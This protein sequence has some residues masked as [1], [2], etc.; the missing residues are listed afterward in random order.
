MAGASR[1]IALDIGNSTVKLAQFSVQNGAL[2]LLAYGSRELGLDPNNQDARFPVVAGVLQELVKEFRLKGKPVNISVAGHSVF[3]RFVKLPKVDANQLHQMIGFEA[4]QNVPFPISE[5][6]WDYQLLRGPTPDQNEAIIVAIKSDALEE[7]YRIA[8]L[9]GFRPARVDISTLALYNAYR[10]N[11]ETTDDCTLLIDIGAKS[12]NFFFIEKDRVYIRSGVPLAGNLL[13][14]SIAADLNEPF[15]S[16]ETLKKGKGFVSLGGAYADPDDPEAARI[17][18]VIRNTMTKLH[19]DINRTTI[20]YRT[21][22]G[23]TN[24]RR[25]LLAGGSSRIPY[26]DVFL[27]EKLGLTV[28]F[29]NPLRNVNIGPNLDQRNLTNDMSSM[30][31]LVGLALRETGEC[32]VEVT[33][34]PPS[35]KAARTKANKQPFLLFAAVAFA[36]A[37][38][39]PTLWNIRQTNEQ[40]LLADNLEQE[41]S[42]LDSVK[43]DIQKNAP[44]VKALQDGQNAVDRLHQQ[45]VAWP[46]I[47]GALHSKIPAG[48]WI[49]SLEPVYMSGGKPFAMEAEAVPIDVPPAPPATNAPGKPPGPKPPASTAPKTFA[50]SPPISQINITGLFHSDQQT[51]NVTSQTM[52]GFGIALAELGLFDIDTR[53]INTTIRPGTSAANTELALKFDMELKLKQ[54]LPTTP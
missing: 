51:T 50:G 35:V 32:P 34:E 13:T 30:G 40:N 17:S 44:E 39:L 49:T 46:R 11:Y 53:N 14:Q 47:L 24:P 42:R 48:S 9:G 54:P 8:S 20:L 15:A 31:E 45:I 36:V 25:V 3:T 33:L 29:F 19:N 38:A 6:T 43:K 26:L 37:M 16:A 52:L 10:Y 18:K 4:Q 22:Q 21:N 2:T 5:V 12:T 7:E 41:V 1:I 23:G 27:A 28:A